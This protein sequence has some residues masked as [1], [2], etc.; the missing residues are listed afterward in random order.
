MAS[1]DE[2]TVMI[3]A[4]ATLPAGNSDWRNTY[5]V[6]GNGDVV[7]ASTFSPGGKVPELPRLGLQGAIGKDYDTMTWYGRGPQENYWDRH[8][9]AAVGQYSGKIEDLDHDYVKPQEN[10][11][12]TDVRWVAW[13]NAAGEGLMAVGLPLLSVSS[14]T[15]TQD[16]LEKAMHINNLPREDFIT[17]NLDYKQTGVGGDDSWGA[18][19]HTQYTL[20]P[21][22]Y[23]YMFCLR[24][25]DKTTGSL[26]AVG[27]QP[28]P[29]IKSVGAVE[30]KVDA[31][32]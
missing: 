29:E 5:I 15:Y 30:L 18:K 8:T 27:R 10:G 26:D 3:T 32:Q 4:D 7:V 24:A 31:R 19:P 9:G 25:I 1:A 17:I 14:W 11:N 2:K 16:N 23:S 6:Y 21:Q 22:N 13:T 12:R 20:W 28:L